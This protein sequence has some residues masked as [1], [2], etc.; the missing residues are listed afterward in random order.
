[1]FIELFGGCHKDFADDG[2]AFIY[3]EKGCCDVT[4]YFC[5]AAEYEPSFDGDVPFNFAGNEDFFEVEI[6]FDKAFWAYDEITLR[7]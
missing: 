6:S 7:F 3:G 4:A 5:S 2:D 1:L